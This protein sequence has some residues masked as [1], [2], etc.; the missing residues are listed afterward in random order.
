[1]LA[2][3]AR[4]VVSGNGTF[5]KGS[6]AEVALR[7]RTGSDPVE[8][9]FLAPGARPGDTTGSRKVDAWNPVTRTAYESKSGYVIEARLAETLEQIRKDKDFLAVLR[10]RLWNGTSSPATRALSAQTPVSWTPSTHPR[11]SRTTCTCREETPRMPMLDYSALIPAQAQELHQREVARHNTVLASLADR[12]AANGGDPAALDGTPGSLVPLWRWYVAWY[13]AGGVDRASGA[14]P[15]W[16]TR[17]MD[18]HEVAYP[19]GLFVVAD[20]V[21]HYLDEVALRDVPGARWRTVEERDGVRFVDFQRTAV[22]LDHLDLVG[23]DLAWILCLRV[24]DGQNTDEGALLDA[25]TRRTAHLPGRS[26]G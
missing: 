24:Q 8:E 16:Y 12:V 11:P 19:D 23:T 3:R 10:V 14:L 2:K 25:Y 22:A 20:E 18:P 7:T 4:G 26:S 15:P 5:A 17:G 13:Q 21:G 1:M 9:V 6:D